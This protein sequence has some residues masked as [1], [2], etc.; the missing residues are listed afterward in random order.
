MFNASSSW[1][2]PTPSFTGQPIA[3]GRDANVYAPGKSCASFTT[4]NCKIEFDEQTLAR[5]QIRPNDTVIE[6][7]AR[8]G[9]TSCAIAEAQQ[10][11]GRL[12]VVEPDAR[13][14]EALMRNRVHNRCSFHAVFGTVGRLPVHL[15]TLSP[16]HFNQATKVSRTGMASLPNFP[17]RSIEAEIGSQFNVALVDC[18]GCFRNSVWDSGL[19]NQ[20]RLVI[21]EEDGGRR[22]AREWHKMLHGAG[23]VRVWNAYDHADRG[24]GN[25]SAWVRA[26]SPSAARATGSPSCTHYRKLRKIHPRH[27]PCVDSDEK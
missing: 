17:F 26:S 12:V 27:L 23:F 19:I 6:F 15:A 16:F 11:S 7:G 21:L 14:H 3:P 24:W 9:T 13:A 22:S 1:W 8:Y 20:L 2:R 10:N 25:H 4:P 18:E 5:A